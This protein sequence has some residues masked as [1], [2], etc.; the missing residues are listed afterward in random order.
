MLVSV[1]ELG[2]RRAE[3]GTSFFQAERSYFMSFALGYNGVAM[4]FNELRVC[5]PTTRS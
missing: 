5:F 1:I 4:R 3:Q 2:K